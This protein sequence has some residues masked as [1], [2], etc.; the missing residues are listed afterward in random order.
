MWVVPQAISSHP[1][2][3]WGLSQSYFINMAKDALV[4]LSLQEIPRAVGALCQE[5]G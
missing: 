3:I 2:I 1:W 4:L 5:Q